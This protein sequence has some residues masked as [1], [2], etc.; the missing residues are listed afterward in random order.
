[1]EPFRGIVGRHKVTESVRTHGRRG[2]SGLAFGAT[3]LFPRSKPGEA[4][5]SFGRRFAASVVTRLFWNT[6]NFGRQDWVW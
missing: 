1:M 2:G 4:N 5:V 6:A 3:Q